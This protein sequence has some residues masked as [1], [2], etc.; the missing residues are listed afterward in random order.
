MGRSCPLPSLLPHPSQEY[1]TCPLQRLGP[2]GE[3]MSS[4]GS[5]LA[6]SRR[7][8]RRQS[9]SGLSGGGGGGGGRGEGSVFH[10]TLNP[11]AHLPLQLIYRPSAVG[12]QDIE[13][14]LHTLS[15]GVGSMQPIRKVRAG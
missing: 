3:V 15:N 1:E 9:S 8:S 14:E 7:I 11:N 2:N 13:L 4:R 10:I 12:K 6:G 5:S